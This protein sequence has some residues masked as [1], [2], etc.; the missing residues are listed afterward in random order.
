MNLQDF[1]TP[2]EIIACKNPIKSNWIVAVDIGFSSVKGMS[3]NK[4]FCF[5]SYVKKMDNN[6]M[7][8]DEDDIYYRDESGVYLIGT[9]AQDLVRTDDTNDTDSSFDRNRYYTKEFAIMA[10]TAVAIGLMDNEERKFEPQFKPAVQTGLPAAYLKEDAPKIKAAFTQPGIYEVRLGSGKWMRFENTLKNGDV[11]VMSQ[12]AGT[13]NS[14]MFND[15]GERVDDAK[16][17]MSKN[18][19]VADIGFGTFDPYGI[20]NRKKALEESINNLGMKRVLEVASGYIYKDY[21]MDIR[22]PQMR[23]YMKEGFFKVIDIQNTFTNWEEDYAEITH[24]GKSFLENW[25]NANYQVQTA[26][27]E[28]VLFCDGNTLVMDDIAKKYAQFSRGIYW[29][30]RGISILVPEAYGKWM[31]PATGK[32]VNGGDEIVGGFND[33]HREDPEVYEA[34]FAKYGGVTM[35]QKTGKITLNDTYTGYGFR[36]AIAAVYE[37]AY[38]WKKLHKADQFGFFFFNRRVMPEGTTI[39]E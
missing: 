14:I 35:D 7:S 36:F 24:R 28:T 2:Q 18:I 1:N 34:G 8:V 30:F 9:K 11:N 5:P 25:A 6:L 38:G 10:R 31:N 12:P 20:I 26:D 22:I 3:P 21:H 13:L 32:E 33:A 37:Y 19:I 17:L 16:D 4:R 15:D 29:Y 23:K 27:G 39:P